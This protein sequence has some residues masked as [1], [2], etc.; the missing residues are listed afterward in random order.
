MA[1]CRKPA[2]ITNLDHLMFYGSS[3]DSLSEDHDV[4]ADNTSATSNSSPNGLAG[5]VIQDF[6]VP[7]IESLEWNM[8]LLQEPEEPRRTRR[9]NTAEVLRQDVMRYA[10]LM[11]EHFK[12]D[13]KQKLKAEI[14]EDFA[15]QRVEFPPGPITPACIGWQSSQGSVTEGL[16]GQ[17]PIDNLTVSFTTSYKCTLITTL[18]HHLYRF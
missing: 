2:C 9:K 5:R 18:L 12:V 8:G 1:S 14:M 15:N 7:D 3:I 6:G 16:V 4:H 11:F 17:H 10:A 13:A